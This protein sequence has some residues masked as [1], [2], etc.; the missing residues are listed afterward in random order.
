MN[1]TNLDGQVGVLLGLNELLHLDPI[2]LDGWPVGGTWWSEFVLS[3]SLQNGQSTWELIGLMTVKNSKSVGNL[4]EKV[5]LVG[6]HLEK[7]EGFCG[8]ERNNGAESM[9]IVCFQRVNV[10]L[11]KN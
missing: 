4:L 1:Q 10:I 5:E 3:N 2:G 11:N 8:W 6:C 9:R 7:N